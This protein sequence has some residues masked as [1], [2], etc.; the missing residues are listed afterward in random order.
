[1][2]RT[3]EFNPANYLDS[4]EA[5]QE[6]WKL[7]EQDGDTVLLETTKK[8]ISEARVLHNLPAQLED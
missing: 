5:I 6:Y 4:E 7:A 1:M 2:E 3:R 8:V